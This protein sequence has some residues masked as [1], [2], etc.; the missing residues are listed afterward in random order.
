MM[1]QIEQAGFSTRTTKKLIPGESF[2][3]FVAINRKSV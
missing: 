2:Y 1:A 3:A